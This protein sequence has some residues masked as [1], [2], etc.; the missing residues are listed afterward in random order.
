MV[1]NV[2]GLAVDDLLDPVSFDLASGECVAIL[3]EHDLRRTALLECI[4]GVRAPDAGSVSAPPAAA[5]WHED[6]LPESTAV[7]ESITQRLGDPA[8]AE[9]LLDRL[10]LAHRAGHEPWAMSAG[11]RRRIAVE[12]ALSSARELVVL[13]EPERGLDQASMSWLAARLAEVRDGG[14]VVVLAT[15]SEWLADQVADVVVEQL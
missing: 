14:A 5:V 10:A 7:S 13:D 15:Y 12:L 6:G 9:S 1:V 11:E 4:A 8:A 3:D 2:R